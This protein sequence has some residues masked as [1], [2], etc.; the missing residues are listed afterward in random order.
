MKPVATTI[1]GTYTIMPS[2]TQTPK[3]IKDERDILASNIYQEWYGRSPSRVINR[4]RTFGSVTYF[5]KKQVM[6]HKHDSTRELIFLGFKHLDG[7]YIA[8]DPKTQGFKEIA[9]W[10]AIFNE[11]TVTD[12]WLTDI[13]KGKIHPPPTWPP[14]I[15]IIPTEGVEVEN[16]DVENDDTTTETTKDETHEQTHTATPTP[17]KFTRMKAPSKLNPTLT[18]QSLVPR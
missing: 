11:S 13:T 17:R 9:S 12:T 18:Y 10:H 15:R 16:D 5:H 4:C 3:D 14:E 6:W 2:R 8:V 7:P 1:N